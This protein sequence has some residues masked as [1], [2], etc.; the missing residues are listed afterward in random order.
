[1]T[2]TTM[3]KSAMFAGLIALAG[4]ATQSSTK[5]VADWLGYRTDGDGTL[6]K[7]AGGQC[8]RTPSWT[9]ALAVLECDVAITE[10][11]ET[12]PVVTAV[13]STAPVL[14]PGSV[15][16]TFA[17]NAA[18]LSAE[19]K[20]TLQA[21]YQRVPQDAGLVVEIHAY[22]DP[23]G[24]SAGNA[25]LA[26]QRSQSVAQWWRS[27]GGFAGEIRIFPHGEDHSVTGQACQGKPVS[28]RM[29]CYAP[30]RRATLLVVRP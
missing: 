6:L 30:D 22:S 18:T 3:M 28:E 19:S 12:V 9:P 11:S 26:H 2:I 20:N 21:W 5:D 4:C 17:F 25:E 14:L 1:M 8:W 7:T 15:T 24:G 16:V 27:Q 10:V 23:L 13:E 29:A